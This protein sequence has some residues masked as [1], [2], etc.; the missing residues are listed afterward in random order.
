MY[1]TFSHEINIM[2]VL[3]KFLV[4][5]IQESFIVQQAGYGMSR[6]HSIDVFTQI[7]FLK[8]TFIDI[9]LIWKIHL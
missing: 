5:K 1:L 6:N 2:H 9:S 8:T 7:P 3:S 4:L